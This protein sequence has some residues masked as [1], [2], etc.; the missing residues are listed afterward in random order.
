MPFSSKSSIR[1]LPPEVQNQ[2]AAGE[3]VE[4]PSS[5]VKELV[6]NSLDAEAG[7]VRVD[8]RDGGRGAITVRDDGRGM[9]A[10]ELPLAL[11]RHAT[12]KLTSVHDL[13]TM[14]SF[15]FR[16]E[17]LPSIA[18]VSSCRIT[19]ARAPDRETEPEEG[20]FIQ[21]VHGR[22]TDQ[23]PAAPARGTLVE[24]K[25]LF[26][27]VPA[28]LKFLKTP[29]TET[30]RCT[31][32]FARMALAHLDVDLELTQGDRTLLRFL[33][34]QTLHQRVR[35][36]WPPQVCEGLRELS[37]SRN[38]LS[39]RGLAGSPETAQ[40][41]GDRIFLYVNGRPV[42]DKMLL[43][44][45]RQAY[46][47][48]LLSREYPQA[49][50][51]LDIPPDH[52]DVNVH[53]AKAEVRFQDESEIFSLLHRALDQVFSRSAQARAPFAPAAPAAEQ[54][55]MEIEVPAPSARL[56][57]DRDALRDHA[58]LFAH[59]PGPVET[60]SAPVPDPAD[61]AF[62]RERTPASTV[63]MPAVSSFEEAPLTFEPERETGQEPGPA[64][65]EYLGQLGSTYLIFRTGLGR[66][67]ELVDQHAAHERVLY[68][69]F[70]R[71]GRRADRRPL[72]MPLELSLHPAQADRMTEMWEE[73]TSLGF[74]LE[75]P[76]D[77]AVL[78]RTIPVTLTPGEAREYIVEAL[79]D[80]GRSMD[81]LW[82]MLACRSAIKAGQELTRD[83]A[84]GLLA[85]W[86]A[87]E[88]PEHCPHGRPVRISF[89]MQQLEK[90]FKRKP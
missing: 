51:F 48:R 88:S 8:I 35:T 57:R 50:L 36:L 84:M 90:L 83:E 22:I 43:G 81:D 23:G 1:V 24:I 32:I 39:V 42:Q 13:D 65:P 46:K 53:P 34:G 79:T 55:S 25:D 78:I 70:R 87:T 27:N 9:P 67:L 74:S 85:G 80:Q 61:T 7:V 69:Q 11:T 64:E 71:Q 4:R 72:V 28:R 52:V 38:A 16:G 19:S 21:V 2:I 29:A 10:E 60:P 30:K 31:D 3:V 56:P 68:E 26:A 54:G 82:I 5:V 62:G 63:P 86:Q 14:A 47:G 40:S 45:L 76:S 33:R 41:R 77:T 58:R 44:A 75:R 12:S 73:L 37:F 49:V 59:D 18:S 89:S 66:E 17:A 15:G 20:A 6:E